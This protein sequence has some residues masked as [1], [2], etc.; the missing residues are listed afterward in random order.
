M[1]QQSLTEGLLTYGYV[2]E[3]DDVSLEVC[4]PKGLSG[5]V[6]A[7]NVSPAY[8]A[9]LKSILK[10]VNQDS[11]PVTLCDLYP[12]GS[13]IVC[14]VRSVKEGSCQLS[15]CPKDVNCNLQLDHIKKK[16][17][18]IGSVQ[19]IEDHGYLIDI[20]L[21][22]LYT[23]LSTDNASK[24][25]NEV[26]KVGQQLH[27]VVTDVTYSS[28]DVIRS[29]SVTADPV[30]VATQLIKSQQPVPI[31]CVCPG[32][33]AQATLIEEKDSHLVATFLSHRAVVPKYYCT[34][35]KK[36]YKL[37]STIR[38]TV[39]QFNPHTKSIVLI[40]KLTPK[41]RESEPSVHKSIGKVVSAVVEWISFSEIFLCLSDGL[42]GFTRL[43]YFS[44]HTGSTTSQTYPV[45][46]T[47][48][49]RV[50]RFLPLEN[51][52]EVSFD[53][54]EEK[55]KIEDAPPS[56]TVVPVKEP[57]PE[58]AAKPQK[59][60]PKPKPE[61]K[62]EEL[63]GRLTYATVI[64]KL[65]DSFQVQLASTGNVAE[66]PQCHLSDF[67]ELSDIMWDNYGAKDL[68]RVVNFKRQQSTTI[69][70]HKHS[71]ISNV[72]N[73]DF[74][75]YFE[76]IKKGDILTG[77]VR[78]V[79][80]YG[81]FIEYPRGLHSMANYKHASLDYVTDMSRYFLKGMTLK[82]YVIATNAAKHHF[83]VYLDRWESC[84]DPDF[85]VHYFQNYFQQKKTVVDMLKQN[86]D[87]P[88]LLV[89]VKVGDVCEVGIRKVGPEGVQCVLASGIKGFIGP[90]HVK[91]L[92]LKKYMD[93]EAVV[94]DVDLVKQSVEL[95]ASKTVVKRVK[96]MVKEPIMISQDKEIVAVVK[97]V[98][99][100]FVLV[101]LRLEEGRSQLA[102][103]SPKLHM[104][105][106]TS[107]DYYKPGDK[108]SVQFSHLINGHPV[109]KLHQPSQHIDRLKLMGKQRKKEL[110]T[111]RTYNNNNRYDDD[112]GD[113]ESSKKKKG[114]ATKRKHKDDDD[115]G[116]GGGKMAPKK[117]KLSQP[118][119]VMAPVYFSWDN[120][121]DAQTTLQ[122]P[123]PPAP[124]QNGHISSDEEEEEEEDLEDQ[125]GNNSINLLKKKKAAKKLEQK[126]EEARLYQIE[127]Q[128][129]MGDQAPETADDFDRL[130]LN[131]PNSSMLWLR[132]MAFHLET[133]EVDKARAVA[134]RALK[135]ILFREEQEKF[136]VW[137]AY[138]NLE[139]LYGSKENVSAVLQRALQQ[140]QPLKVY[141]QLVNVYI[142]SGKI[143]AAREVYDIL[144]RRFRKE[145]DVWIQYAV[146]CY[147]NGFLEQGRELIEK[148]VR[149][150]DKKDHVSLVS[151][152]AQLEFRHGDVQRGRSMFESI[153]SNYPRRTDLWSIYIDMAM[154]QGDK[155]QIRHLFDRVTN[156]RL[157][158]RKMGFFY[159]RYLN[160][161]EKNG[162]KESVVA[163]R[164]KAEQYIE[165]VV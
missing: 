123:P 106:V 50:I 32:M 109:V 128:R 17:V 5:T 97:F 37:N 96:K 89:D 52:F 105:D 156:L 21:K 121:D 55:E 158:T 66:L 49:C 137:I 30:K 79:A 114:S 4:L 46:S 56:N 43:P 108:V 140:N 110:K 31:D 151:K 116:G 61:K 76:R 107:W 65:E 129:V 124:Q 11:S 59:I 12:E 20:G 14:K 9:Y 68:L 163:V 35:K 75:P 83:K 7:T 162:T 70:S 60:E 132:Y 126:L 165:G 86:K 120:D 77:V 150:I 8:T 78:S 36:K 135:T 71:L 22:N 147:K 23:F 57:E 25:S 138:L 153:V 133:A 112:A 26:L 91:G 1:F 48:S 146:F 136:N 18:V 24:Y 74:M 160:F 2:T 54:E 98:R 104:N 164:E 144:M 122:A 92:T 16:L 3:S 53:I 93:I 73:R 38:A 87:F 28:L 152:V 115:G 40:P 119:E 155:E 10:K 103:L 143:Q 27:C 141:Q 41:S 159:K 64:K 67:Q 51:L 81:V 44:S 34:S 145:K 161:E 101:M 131:S 58:T 19:S 142:K 134:E 69:C 118:V 80:D 42:W 45:G 125:N 15:L 148:A 99:R 130:L 62:K 6:S 33:L 139:N 13:V 154:L 88:S 149:I 47:H 111:P 82:T 127:R 113:D 95:I 90:K 94:L 85:H 84:I 100:D 72:I 102:Y 117:S 157:S 29:V 39:L 63:I